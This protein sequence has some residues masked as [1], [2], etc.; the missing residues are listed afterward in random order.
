MQVSGREEV[1]ASISKLG[2]A[3]LEDEVSVTITGLVHIP[4][5]DG[6][7]MLSHTWHIGLAGT[8]SW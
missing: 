1:E 8:A 3:G 6:L 5:F 4:N 2:M 7:G